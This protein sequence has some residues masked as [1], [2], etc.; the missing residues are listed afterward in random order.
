MR[1]GLQVEWNRKPT[2]MHAQ[3]FSRPTSHMLSDW[4]ST[5]LLPLAHWALIRG[6]LHQPL[7]WAAKWAAAQASQGR[8]GFL[9][10]SGPTFIPS[11]LP[12]N[13][14][15]RQPY[16]QEPPSPRSVRLIGSQESITECP[17]MLKALPPD[18]SAPHLQPAIQ[19][20]VAALQDPSAGSPA[21]LPEEAMDMLGSTVTASEANASETPSEQQERQ[22]SEGILI[23]EL[24][25]VQDT[26]DEDD[27]DYDDEEESDED[28]ED[29][30]KSEQLPVVEAKSMQPSGG[31]PKGKGIS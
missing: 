22:V 29:G 9:S 17:P 15:W 18:W 20:A 31:G 1:L 10:P 19:Q 25:S 24:D 27:D 16:V 13:R 12:Q 23:P 28:E 4:A 6:V 14:P 7:D 21:Q 3:L 8:G 11:A 5:R 30:E 2:Y 26:G